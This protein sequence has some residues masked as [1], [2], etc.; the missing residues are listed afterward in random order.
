VKERFKYR[1]WALTAIVVAVVV[2]P[3]TAL[4]ARLSEFPV[5]DGPDKEL[6]GITLGP[7]GALWF[8]E[9]VG[10]KIGRITTSGSVK[11]FPLPTDDAEASNITTG[12]DGALWFGEVNARQVGRITTQGAIREFPVGGVSGPCGI[13]AGRDGALWFTSRGS[14]I[15][16]PSD[17]RIGRITTGG[18]VA[19]AP[20]PTPGAAPAEITTGPDGA[21]WFT[22]Y[23]T[24]KIGRITT[25]GAVSEFPVPGDGA[26]DGIT[27]GSDGALW[28][29]DIGENRVGRITTAGQVRL[30]PMPAPDSNP[31]GITSGPDGALWF[32]EFDG[33]KIGRITTSGQI[34]EL[35]TFSNPV[36]IDAGPDGGMWFTAAD[37]G[38]I[39]RAEIRGA[40]IPPRP[41][42]GK[43]VE[44]V[45]ISGEGKVAQTS[46]R[47]L[48]IRNARL[49][50]VNSVVD[51]RRGTVGLASVASRTSKLNQGRFSGGKFR[52]RQSRRRKAK[53]LTLLELKGGSFRGCPRRGVHASAAR[54]K[55]TIRRLRGSAHGRF[56]T[57][58]RYASATVRGTKWSVEDRCDGT[59]TK[60]FEGKVAVRDFRRHKTIT[61]RA[62][63]SY[64]AR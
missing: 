36:E 20:I 8:T 34:S 52:V 61:V 56:Q 31:S 3:S 55:R 23:G 60:V 40:P 47:L 30:F 14:C 13:A 63:K 12:S 64:L 46:A 57:R 50:R 37:T 16:G 21:L 17:N 43:N 24:S 39:G 19:F 28:F 18:A 42:V 4:A 1:W 5:P 54:R 58:G 11:E 32:T 9:F 25:G 62:G 41:T 51:T 44:L 35:P 27:V 10:D 22:E 59:L 7:D 48:P 38:K 53:G 29:A 2:W 49:S 15:D 26:P 45:P 6:E 33:A